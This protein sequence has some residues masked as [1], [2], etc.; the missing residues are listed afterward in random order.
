MADRFIAELCE[1][2]RDHA[3]RKAALR[4]RGGGSKDFYGNALK[5]EVIDTAGHHGIIAYEPAE[6]VIT[7]RAGTRLADIEAA[8]AAQDQM[9]AFEPP[10]FGDRATLG[11]AVAAGLS[12]PRRAAAGSVRDFVLGIKLLDGRGQPLNFGGRV[13]KNVAGYDVSRLVAGSLG[14]L[15]LI[16]EVSL[17]VLPRPRAT[18]TLRFEM[19]QAGA[20]AK[21]NQWAGKPLPITA[22][23]WRDDV[24]TLRLAGAAQAGAAAVDKLGGEVVPQD[25]AQAFWSDLREQRLDFFGG[26]EPLWR[27]SLPSTA[28]APKLPG[29]TLIE[30]GGSQRWLKSGAAIATVRQAAAQLGGHATL[31]R[32][33]DKTSGV[34][35][36][37]PAALAAL[38]R[39]VRQS[40]DPRGV[41]DTGRL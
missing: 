19:P 34:F 15:G 41:F 18:A 3:E 14:T 28:A 9:L 33:G 32:G 20:L 25:E 13:I 7:A 31:F 35:Q 4:I 23:A 24:L 30:W 27:L 11:G 26:D 12:G 8:V 2:V 37:L 6:L 39:R 5:G 16:L 22:S 17:K 29:A 36:P 1:R 40:L 10:H 38:N 21:M